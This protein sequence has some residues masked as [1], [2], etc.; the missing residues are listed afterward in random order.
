[1]ITMKLTTIF[2]IVL[3]LLA[4]TPALGC[5]EVFGAIELGA[6]FLF[7]ITVDNGLVTCDTNWGQGNNPDGSLYV[8]CLSGYAYTVSSDGQT[9]WYNNPINGFQFSQ[10]CYPGEAYVLFQD[11]YFG[12]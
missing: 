8:N 6:L 12:C 10:N 9:G 1:M 4:I 7:A 11:T 3:Q 2:S 5:L